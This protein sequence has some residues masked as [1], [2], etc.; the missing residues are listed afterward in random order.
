MRLSVLL[1]IGL[2]LGSYVCAHWHCGKPSHG[3]G[4]AVDLFEEAAK[5]RLTMA[6]WG[7][8]L[9]F[10]DRQECTAYVV[11]FDEGFEGSHY[12]LTTANCFL[13]K[14]RRKATVQLIPYAVENFIKDVH[15]DVRFP[16]FALVQFVDPVSFQPFFS[17]LCAPSPGVRYSNKKCLITRWVEFNP[18]HAS[19]MFD[20]YSPAPV[21]CPGHAVCA[22]AYKGKS[23]H[24]RDEG[25]ALICRKTQ[26]WHLVG[27]SSVKQ[28]YTDVVEF[29]RVSSFLAGL[30]AVINETAPVR[31]PWMVY[32]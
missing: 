5:H 14:Q 21:D 23:R 31:R 3:I 19:M 11:D 18:R 22:K 27:L 13:G 28:Q 1:C 10:Q 17:P 15:L 4:M 12:V 29:T 32:V 6:P 26:R 30:R 9:V 25:I 8:R 24:R 7:A 16:D 20:L 2:A